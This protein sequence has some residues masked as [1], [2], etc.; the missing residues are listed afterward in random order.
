MQHRFLWPGLG[1]FFAVRFSQFA[2]RHADAFRAISDSTREQLT[3]WAEGKPIE[4]FSTWTDIEVFLDAGQEKERKSRGTFLYVGLL[5]PLK[6]VDVLIRAFASIAEDFPEAQLLIVGKA[7]YSQSSTQS[8]RS[9]TTE[10]RA[11]PAGRKPSALRA[12]LP[13]VNTSFVLS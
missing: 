13:P 2:L 12:L 1:R 11:E 8:M 7:A 5:I 6:G 9:L 4:Q 10:I 3:E